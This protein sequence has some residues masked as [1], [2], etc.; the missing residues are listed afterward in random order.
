MGI[1]SLQTAASISTGVKSNKFWDNYTVPANGI[2]LI[3]Q[4]VYT[5]SGS[6][7]IVFNSIPQTYSHLYIISKF[8]DGDTSNFDIAFTNM[9]FNGTNPSNIETNFTYGYSTNAATTTKYQNACFGAAI[10]RG[11]GPAGAY[12]VSVTYIPFYTISGRQKHFHW[13]T[14]VSG[15][16]ST[17]G[18]YG[19][20][21]AHNGTTNPITSLAIDPGNNGWAAGS[22]VQVYGV[23]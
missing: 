1:R 21:N 3:A 6:G 10:Q 2:E 9:Q 17:W 19:F 22:M 15:F 23:K 18:F 14:G 5:S 12:A 4:Q 13:E 20:G 16:S 11:N 8:R 7:Q